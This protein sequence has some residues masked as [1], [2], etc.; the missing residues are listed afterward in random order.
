MITTTTKQNIMPDRS[1]T[2]IPTTA[3]L[4]GTNQDVNVKYT[5]GNHNNNNIKTIKIIKLPK[6]T[7]TIGTWN[8]RTVRR[9]GK[10]EELMKELSRYKWDMNG[11]AEIRLTGDGGT[12][13]GHRLYYSGQGKH[14]EG[15]GFMVK[16]KIQNSVINYTAVSSRIISI[17]IKAS[18]M[19]IIIENNVTS[20]SMNIT[21]IQIHAPTTAYTDEEIEHFYE[22][23]DNTIKETPKKDFLII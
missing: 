21:I 10:L 5:T 22:S 15:V 16:K 23:I 6:K 3:L 11:L 19:H 14:Y 12:T 18:P 1:R 9:F 2:G 7:T 17:R 8:V 20:F 4:I 13:E